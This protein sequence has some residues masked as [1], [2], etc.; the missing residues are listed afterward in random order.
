MN[1]FG[2]AL[3]VPVERRY[4]GLSGYKKMLDE[5]GVLTALSIELEDDDDDPL[6]DDLRG[7]IVPMVTNLNLL[8][9]ACRHCDGRISDSEMRA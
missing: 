5:A 3:Q 2:N 8:L 9:L 7:G 4:T 6:A 1:S